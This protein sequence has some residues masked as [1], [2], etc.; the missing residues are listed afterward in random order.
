MT[1]V[2]IQN[3]IES[4]EDA[5]EP[6]FETALS[7]IPTTPIM[8]TPLSPRSVN[9]RP[10]L[11][12]VKSYASTQRQ[13]PSTSDPKT[14][15]TAVSKKTE[16]AKDHAPPPPQFVI[17][18]PGPN[19]IKSEKY[20]TGRELGKGG[21][22]I[23]YEAKLVGKKHGTDP[24]IVALKIVKAKMGIKKMEEKVCPIILQQV[25]AL[26]NSFLVPDGITNPLENAAQKY[27]RVPSC[28][29]ISGKHLPCP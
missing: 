25:H 12:P 13:K 8:A 24:K 21:F 1:S 4:T 20:E 9:I 2:F 18:P 10:T 22:A 23:C 7:T 27:S 6:V 3:S 29:H 17:Q 26:T 15:S 11:A 5:L 16:K 28:I 14:L 19:G